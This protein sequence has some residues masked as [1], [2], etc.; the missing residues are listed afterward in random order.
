MDKLATDAYYN[1]VDDKGKIDDT[2]ADSNSFKND[3]SFSANET[4]QIIRHIKYPD[5]GVYSLPGIWINGKHYV[6]NDVQIIV[7]TPHERSNIIV[8]LSLILTAL[9]A[10]V[11]EVFIQFSPSN[12]KKTEQELSHNN[13]IRTI[14][15]LIFLLMLSAIVYVMYVVSKELYICY[16]VP[17]I[18]ILLLYVVFVII[19]YKLHPHVADLVNNGWSPLLGKLKKLP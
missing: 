19:M 1:Y 4:K 11:I 6:F 17:N 13:L 9:G 7:D 16:D 5:N 14:N 2:L 3:S 12:A 15:T 18:L 8:I 10:L